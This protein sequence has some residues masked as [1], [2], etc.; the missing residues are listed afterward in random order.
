MTILVTGGA[1]YIGSAIVADLVAEGH[2]TIVVDDLSEGHWEAVDSGAIFFQ[3]DYGDSALLD[4]IFTDHSI[5]CVIHLAAQTLVELSMREPHLF[6]QVNVVKGLALLEAMRRYGCH[7][8]IFSSTAAVFGEPV[9]VPIT[10]QHPTHPINSYGESK[11]HF[12]QILNWYHRAYGFKYNA[13]RYF[14]AAG[15]HP[16][17]GEDHKTESHLI[18]LV[19]FAAMGKMKAIRVFGTDY[20]TRDG[21]CVRDY[22]HICDLSLAHRLALKNLDN[23]PAQCYNLGNSEGDTVLE[24]IETAKKVTGR[25]IP[26]ILEGR[27]SGDPAVLVASSDLARRELGWEPKYPDLEHIIQTAWEWHRTHPNGYRK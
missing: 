27:R 23:H 22:V 24:V 8:M 15:A 10:E 6:F 1:G 9:S 4:R 11:R 17:H 13:F 26:T 14:N 18:P 7:R 5:D 16:E 12:E 3:G 19:L 25:D 2:H 21:S 20:P